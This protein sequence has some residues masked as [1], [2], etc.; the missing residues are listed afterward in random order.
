MFCTKF[1]SSL[2]F[3]DNPGSLLLLASTEVSTISP[4]LEEISLG[5][6]QF[7]VLLF[8]K[9][10][11][12]VSV[13]LILFVFHSLSVFELA[14]QLF[15]HKICLRCFP[16]KKELIIII[17]AAKLNPTA[18]KKFFALVVEHRRGGSSLPPKLSSLDRIIFP[19]EIP[20]D[21]SVVLELEMTLFELSA[22]IQ[23]LTCANLF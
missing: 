13:G 12:L 11:L 5:T 17:T 1:T 23:H 16:G 8:L 14:P 9:N 3:E 20:K 7:S 22:N 6:S 18:T 21:D 10:N 4:D 15:K 19:R 2:V